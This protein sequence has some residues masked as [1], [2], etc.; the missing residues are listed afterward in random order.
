V[1]ATTTR[2]AFLGLGAAG[3]VAAA[4]RWAPP[5]DAPAS[6]S[7]RSL[8][9]VVKPRRLQPGDAV[10]IANPARARLTVEEVTAVVGILQSLG[11]EPRLGNRI[12]RAI[13]QRNLPDEEH[14][15]EVNALFRDPEVKAVLPIRGGWGCARLLPYLDYEAIAAHPKVLIGYSDVSALLLGIHSRT[16]LVTFHGPMGT[17]SWVPFTIDCMKEVLFRGAACRMESASGGG[18]ERPFRTLVPGRAEGRLLGGNLTVLTSL[19]GSAYVGVEDDLIL[20]L[21]E[22]LEPLSEVDRMITQLRLAGVLDRVRGLV[23][24]Q[25]TGCVPPGIDAGL[26]LDEVLRDQIAPLGIPTWRGALIGH[27]ERQITLPLGVRAAID[28]D[29]GTIQLLE[30]AVR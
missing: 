4:T 28:A 10:G 22:V 19:L 1:P 3:C 7:E 14:A 11:L 12:E 17:S 9:P 29:A 23:F 6:A 27:I 8:P 2:R 20:F 13:A 5:V 21:E 26:T 30:P 18:F 25:C 15:E 16:G 24:G